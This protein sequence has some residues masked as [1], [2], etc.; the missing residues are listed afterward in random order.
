MIGAGGAVGEAVALAL[1]ARGWEVRALARHFRPDAAARLDGARIT[2]AQAE[3]A[4][5]T[6]ADFAAADAAIVV[7]VLTAA[8]AI[9]PV[10]AAA[11][12]LLFFSSHNVSVHA[13]A[14]V[15]RDIAAAESAIAAAAPHARFIRPTLIYGDPRLPFM[16]RLVRLV[17]ASWITPLPGD[18]AVR[19]QPI[20][21]EDLAALAVQIAESDDIT[22]AV[23]A[24]GAEI[25]TK[26]ELLRRIAHLLGVRRLIA[27]AP[28]PLLRAAAQLA[29]AAG[30]SFPLD[31]AQ[32]DR[33]DHDRTAPDPPPGL[34]RAQTPLDEGL[35]RLIARMDAGGAQA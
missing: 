29:R 19:L 23:P 32:L 8:A 12:R 28:A 1:A 16:P 2:R 5:L 14:P 21:C 7:P 22:G 11:P 35:R 34:A 33:L 27:P 17:R 10:A 24:G 3:L 31:A 9:A 6:Q 25:V 18:G 30:L 15:Y 13:A 26:R 20:F 4:A